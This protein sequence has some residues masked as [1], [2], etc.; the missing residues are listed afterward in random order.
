MGLCRRDVDIARELLRRIDGGVVNVVV[1]IGIEGRDVYRQAIV[2]IPRPDFIAVRGF[3]LETGVRQDRPAAHRGHHIFFL[4]RRSAEALRKGGPQ[5]QIRD[6]RPRKAHVEDRPGIVRGT[7]R[8]HIIRIRT[9]G[10]GLA[11]FG[12]FHLGLNPRIPHPVAQRKIG[13]QNRLHL[14]IQGVGQHVTLVVGRRGVRNAFCHRRRRDLLRKRRRTVQDTGG[15]DALHRSGSRSSRIGLQCIITDVI[16]G[17]QVMVVTDGPVH[18]QRR[19]ELL[20]PVIRI[21]GDD[22]RH[23]CNDRIRV[24]LV[25]HFLFVLLPKRIEAHTGKP[26]R[27]VFGFGKGIDLIALPLGNVHGKIFIT[28]LHASGMDGTFE[29]VQPAADRELVGKVITQERAAFLLAEG[30][31]RRFAVRGAQVPLIAV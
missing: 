22:Q 13:G 15:K 16:S 24:H 31:I 12:M 30:G 29:A 6:A 28:G 9:F 3:R 20:V 7:F 4:Q 25:G 11:P 10:I 23:L 14:C 27:H 2:D 18:L 8:T 17:D 26:R 1:R 5:R 21:V 19:T